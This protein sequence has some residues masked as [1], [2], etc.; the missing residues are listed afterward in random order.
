LSK[1]L[2]EIP[3]VH[4]LSEPDDLT[5]I[6]GLRD[7]DGC[8]DEWLSKLIISS[9]RWR[10]KPRLGPPADWIAIKTRSEVL[11][12]ADLIGPL[13]PHSKHFFLYRNAVSWMGSLFRG[14]QLDRDPYDEELNRKMEESWARTIPLVQEYRRA[15]APMNQI[16]IRILAWVTCM[17][18]YL[19]LTQMELPLCAARFED[20]AE[21]PVPILEQFFGF[22]GIEQVD[23]TAID[24]VLG[25]DSQAGTIF[26]REERRKQGRKLTEAL[27]Q[28]VRDMVATRPLLRTPDVVLPATLRLP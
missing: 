19:K 3:A 26:D 24:E 27:T 28:D 23:W 22:C 4:S 9:T 2:A 13:F 7:A 17:E 6:V 14:Y 16:Q 10:C 1:A 5:Q 21:Q 11:V 8:S 25:R 12:L 20:L 18:A 15:E